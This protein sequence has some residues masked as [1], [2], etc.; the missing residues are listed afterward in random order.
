MLTGCLE[1][2]LT[3]LPSFRAV[4][5]GRPASPLDVGGAQIYSSFLHLDLKGDG[6]E[7]GIQYLS[8]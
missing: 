5:L 3:P 8:P 1:S 7:D 6:V 2:L 4:V